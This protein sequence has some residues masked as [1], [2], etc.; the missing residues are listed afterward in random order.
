VAAE[1]PPVHLL[2][3]QDALRLVREKLEA[4]SAEISSWEEVS[5]STDF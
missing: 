4:L 2:L 5:R 3:G 1:D